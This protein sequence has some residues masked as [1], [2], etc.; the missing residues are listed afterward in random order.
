MSVAIRRLAIVSG[1]QGHNVSKKILDPRCKCTI[2]PARECGRILCGL[3]I[4]HSIHVHNYPIRVLI[5]SLL[6]M[7]FM[8][9]L[10]T[11]FAAAAAVS[12]APTEL[13]ARDVWAPKIL[14]PHAGTVWYSGQRHNVTW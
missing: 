14:Y 5:I 13:A 8:T 12:S 10:S 3:S 11:L 2:K 6:I 4:L 1:Q 7:K 9:L